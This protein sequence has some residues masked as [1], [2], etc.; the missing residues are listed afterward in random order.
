[1]QEK[2]SQNHES[3]ILS[4]LKRHFSPQKER[5]SSP[6]AKA[7]PIFYNKKGMIRYPQIRM[8]SFENQHHIVN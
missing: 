8:L 3:I 1:M 2:P 7:S 4:K 5:M 6:L